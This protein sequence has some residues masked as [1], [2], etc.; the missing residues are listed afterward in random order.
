MD[1]SSSHFLPPAALSA[2]A[3]APARAPE[4]RDEL[5]F[6]RQWMAAQ[7]A[8]ASTLGAMVG[9][10]H[11]VDDLLQEVSLAAYRN[12]ERFD[13]ERDFTGWVIGIAR[14]KAV[15]WLRRRGREMPMDETTLASLTDTACAL[16]DELAAREA[17]LHR[18]LSRLGARAQELLRRRYRDEQPVAE[19][20]RAMGIGLSH[21]KVL[22]HRSRVALR[23]C[24]DRQ[25]AAGT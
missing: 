4:G 25:L 5:A 24:I 6:T 12:L 2:R 19:A 8:V 18:C 3:A 17:A 10:H 22:L 9:D 21:A 13:P 11:A 15:D 1:A 14:H 23:R 7:P 20:A 16:G